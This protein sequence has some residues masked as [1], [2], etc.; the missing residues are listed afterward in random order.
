MNFK[1]ALSMLLLFSFIGAY[2]LY[3]N[4]AQIQDNVF[5]VGT[6]AGYAPFV[7]INEQGE[8]EGFDIDVA[9]LLT[10][11]LGKK[12]ILK[13]LGSMTG[14]FMALN[15]GSIDAI[16]WGLS[17][18]PDRLK[19]VVLI[20]YQ[21]KLI[22]SYPLLFWENI[23]AGITCINDMRGMTICVEPNSSQ[24]A[25]LSKYAFIIK[26]PIEQIDDALLSIQYHK[27]DAALVEPAI[28]KKFKNRYSQIQMLN[29]NLNKEEQ[30]Q[31][32]GIAIKK[33]NNFLIKQI[34]KAINELKRDGIIKQY[35]EKWDVI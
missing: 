28:A 30:E 15:Q 33:E 21:E 14:L 18:T 31:G 11:K 29:V 9:K 7:S 32:I 3:R 24:D 17:I 1:I 23:P 20:N 10:Q 26:K 5:I 2:F 19:K 4:D 34:K 22:T 12:L 25:V 35:E 16:M 13:D 6:T 27:A 8:Y